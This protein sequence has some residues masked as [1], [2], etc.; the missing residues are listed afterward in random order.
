MK[1]IAL[2]LFL[3]TGFL[4]VAACGGDGDNG[5][6]ETRTAKGGKRD[7]AQVDR[8]PVPD[9]FIGITADLNGDPEKG[10]PLYD[11]DCASCHGTGGKG[12]APVGQALNPPAGNLTS[13]DFRAVDD[14]YIYWRIAEGPAGGPR[15]SG[16]TAFK[17][18]FDKEQIGHIIAYIRT[19][20]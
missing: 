7:A 2:A 19:F 20:E 6:G 10:K 16:M 13:A 4:L 9:E 15:G 8:Q 18:M 3:T 14:D 5:N 1:Y 11:R 12:D 17:D